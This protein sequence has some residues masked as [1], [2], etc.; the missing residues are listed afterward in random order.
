MKVLIYGSEGWIGKQFIKLLE[1]KNI[2][3]IKGIE[4]KDYKNEIK[5]SKC[6]HVIAFIGRTHGEGFTTIDYLEQPGKLR[7]NVNDNLYS[8]VIIANACREYNIHFTYLGTGCIFKYQDDTPPEGF[9]EESS[10]NFFGSSYSVVKGFTD[11]ILKDYDHVLNLRIRMPIINENH[12]RN[13]IT[14][15]TTYNKI[16]SIDNSMTV[17]PHLLPYVIKMM[18]MSTSGTYNFTN[19]GIISHNEILEMYRDIVDPSFTWQNFSDKEQRKI[20]LSDRSNNKLDTT[21]LQTLFPDVPT[22]KD[23][24]RWCLENYKFNKNV[25]ITGGCGFIGSAFINRFETYD[26]LVNI[27]A[28]YYCSNP[29]AIPSEKRNYTFIQDDLSDCGKITKILEEHSITHVIHFAA[30][31]HVQ[32]SFHEP[33]IYTRDN[34]VASHNLLE[35]SRIYGKLERFFHISTDE[36]YGDTDCNTIKNEQTILCPT[37]PYSATKA[38]VELI[39]QSYIHSFSMPI[40]ISRMNNVYGPN[41][42]KEKVIPRF[43]DQLKNNEKITIHGDGSSTRDFMYIDDTI[44]GLN[45]IFDKG[46]IGEVYNVG[47]DDGNDI[48]ILELAKLLIKKIKNSEN[49]DEFITYVEDRPYNDKRY[50][51]TNEKLK[52][53]GWSHTVKIEDGINNI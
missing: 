19:P 5:N 18:E 17:L 43:I 15:I 49:Y 6:S 34:I 51:I 35:A 44:S 4:R 25:L 10:P 45:I 50:Y 38:A 21:K 53:L 29:K 14:K 46:K 22:I 20:L 8:P 48:T 41:Q 30:Q 39:I 52:Q 24:V 31:S 23:S 40:I 32:N 9:T 28:L 1:E 26:N 16:C 2:S 27:D 13:F 11:Q 7:E 47:C 37:N 33:L 36:V 3:F 12:S 42:H